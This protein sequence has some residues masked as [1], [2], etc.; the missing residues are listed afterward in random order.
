MEGITTI[1]A[2][3][4]LWKSHK[5]RNIRR[6]RIW[7]HDI[8]RHRTQLGEFHRLLQ[9]LHLNDCRFQRYFRLTCSQ[10][11]DLLA[12]MG[13]RISRLDTNYRHSI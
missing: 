1:A 5:Y 10:L 9:D 3:Y 12:Q 7:V 8:I 4:L 13:A 6:P 11:D 2:L